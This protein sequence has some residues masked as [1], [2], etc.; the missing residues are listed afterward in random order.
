[1]EKKLLIIKPDLTETAKA[2]ISFFFGDF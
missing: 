2:E 1:M